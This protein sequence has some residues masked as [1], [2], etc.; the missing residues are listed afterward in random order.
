MVKSIYEFTLEHRFDGFDLDWEYPA[1]RGGRP[2]DREAFSKLIMEL[3]Q[4]FRPKG[5][6]LSAAVSADAN[7]IRDSYNCRDLA[8][9]LE[10]I[11]VMTYDLHG[12]WEKVTGHHTAMYPNPRDPPSDQHLNVVSI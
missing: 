5:L 3:Q 6:V 2:S 1:Q 8:E 9:N 4:L 7:K 11:N 12:S 10:F